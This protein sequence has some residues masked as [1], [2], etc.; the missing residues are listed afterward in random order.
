MTEEEDALGG[1]GFGW[2]S[3]EAEFEYV[4]VL[5]LAV[6]LDSATERLG[7]GCGEVHAGVYGGFPVGGGLA[8][9]ELSS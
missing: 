8:E 7:V 9:D 2:P 6:A 3:A 1:F 5:F 4:T